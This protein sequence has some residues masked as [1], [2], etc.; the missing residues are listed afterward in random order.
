MSEW[1]RLMKNS[2]SSKERT[3]VWEKQALASQCRYG[4]PKFFNLG[5]YIDPP[6]LETNHHHVAATAH[7]ELTPAATTEI[8]G[9]DTLSKASSPLPVKVPKQVLLEAMERRSN[10]VNTPNSEI[11]AV[12]CD[13]CKANICQ[14]IPDH[15]DKS[16]TLLDLNR[17]RHCY[18][19]RHRKRARCVTWHRK[20]PSF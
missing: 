1:Q 18:T 14:C 19:V 4:S 15:H 10:L 7:E 5:L 12:P 11:V 8:D 13:L 9:T 3:H 17:L 20:Q 6:Q 2:K 16:N